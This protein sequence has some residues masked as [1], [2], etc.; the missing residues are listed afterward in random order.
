MDFYHPVAA[1]AGQADNLGN[2]TEANFTNKLIRRLMIDNITQN[3][4]T[5]ATD[6]G[7]FVAV[8]GAPDTMRDADPYRDNATL[9]RW[10]AEEYWEN[11]PTFTVRYLPF[12]ADPGSGWL[13]VTMPTNDLTALRSIPYFANATLTESSGIYTLRLAEGYRGMPFLTE[14]KVGFYPTL[15]VENTAP[16]DQGGQ[17]SIVTKST[18]K[19]GR[20]PTVTAYG[21]ARS[22]YAIDLRHLQL[23]LPNGVSDVY[24]ANRTAV[25]IRPSGGSFSAAITVPLAGREQEI[26]ITGN[27]EV[28]ARDDEGR[29]TKIAVTLNDLPVSLDIGIPFGRAESIP[30]TG[31]PIPWVIAGFALSGLVLILFRRKRSN[32][33]A[34]R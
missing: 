34:S 9:V 3:P 1:Q 10:E 12:G 7:G 18:A 26:A 29:P 27:V 28:L 16:G 19:D 21:E 32:R 2:V 30:V 11:N 33:K 14:V 25:S 23:S 17:V 31:D 6:T 15:A 8:E 20:Y 4:L 22:G 5:A 24:S 13:S